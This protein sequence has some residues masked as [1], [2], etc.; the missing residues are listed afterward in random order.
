MVSA[1][2]A[3]AQVAGKDKECTRRKV[4]SLVKG[5]PRVTL[6]IQLSR[7]EASKRR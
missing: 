3:G 6:Y 5:K 2:D 7:E 4:L 1:V